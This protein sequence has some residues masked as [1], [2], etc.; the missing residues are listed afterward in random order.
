MTGR[1]LWSFVCNRADVAFCPVAHKGLI[2]W[3]GSDID[4]QAQRVGDPGNSQLAQQEWAPHL[5]EALQWASH[6][7]WVHH[8]N[9]KK[10]EEC[11]QATGVCRDWEFRYGK[12]RISDCSAS[13]Q[14]HIF[15]RLLLTQG[16]R[17]SRE[18]E[19]ESH[20]AATE[21]P[22]LMPGSWSPHNTQLWMGPVIE[23][24]SN[25]VKSSIA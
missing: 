10:S 18:R 13:F 4:V 16:K 3:Q 23:A 17:G 5:P 6:K 19:M 2:D 8:E 9:R 14:S 7:N 20:S 22:T 25:A 12:M 11:L 24:R 15:L 1:P 21:V